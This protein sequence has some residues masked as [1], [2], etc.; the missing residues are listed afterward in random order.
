MILTI[1]NQNLVAVEGVVVAV[2]L[3]S[4][5]HGEVQQRP[6]AAVVGIP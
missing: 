6:E 3:S 2:L 1:T 5:A 4:E